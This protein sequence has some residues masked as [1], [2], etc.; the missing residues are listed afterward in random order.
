MRARRDFEQVLDAFPDHATAHVG[1]ANA[2]AMRFETTRADPQPDR[3]ALEKAGHHAREACRLD[4]GS[5]EAW[6]TRGFVLGCT[7][8]RVDA[9]A[10]LRRAVTLEPD[11]WRHHFRLGY[12]SWGDE[13]LAPPGERWHCC[14]GFR[15]PTGWRRRSMSL[16]TSSPKPNAS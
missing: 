3:S 11:N 10:A 2:H 14:Q 1:L 5:A 12:A 13:R 6:A 7:G 8:E 15:W 9:L 16:A 4:S